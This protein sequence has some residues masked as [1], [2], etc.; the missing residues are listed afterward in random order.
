M[1]VTLLL[2][3]NVA[4]A[5]TKIETQSWEITWEQNTLRADPLVVEKLA[6]EY[7]QALA[8][9]QTASHGRYSCVAFAK[10]YLGLNGTWG[11]GGAYLPLTQIP[12]VGS[13]VVFSYTHVAVI[14]QYSAITGQLTIIEA[15][16]HLDGT[17]DHRTLLVT[18]PTIRGYYT[19]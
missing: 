11:N 8:R 7:N 15:N 14:T 4:K 2:P 6:E 9:T 16:Y 12:A 3:V 18:D 10:A 13:V 17:V 19:P 5:Q 1:I